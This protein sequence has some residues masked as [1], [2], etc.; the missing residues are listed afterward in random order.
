MTYR[1]QCSGEFTSPKSKKRQAEIDRMPPAEYRKAMRAELALKG[2]GMIN[3]KFSES[4]EAITQFV[5]GI[6]K[7]EISFYEF[8][9]VVTELLKRVYPKTLLTFLESYKKNTGKNT[10]LYKAIFT[11][12]YDVPIERLP[13]TTFVVLTDGYDNGNFGLQ[14]LLEYILQ[15]E[16]IHIIIIGV[17]YLIEEESLKKIIK[18]A[19]SGRLLRV[20]DRLE[21]RTIDD[22]FSTAKDLML[23]RTDIEKTESE[24]RDQFGFK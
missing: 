18:C 3:T 8:T 24:I 5:T 12:I 11:Q 1:N 9:D 20:G 19:K 23:M 16:E 2:E 21:F 13:S 22:A 14:K 10:E 4:V 17:G 6:G 7:Y 15:R